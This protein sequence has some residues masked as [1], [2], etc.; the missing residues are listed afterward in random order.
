MTPA[1]PIDAELRDETSISD[2][3]ILR[4]STS[5]VQ[6]PDQSPE[7]KKPEKSLND[8][9]TKV[10]PT[11]KLP[12]PAKQQQQTRIS[13]E[14]GQTHQYEHTPEVADQKPETTN[15]NQ[16]EEEEGDTQN[17]LHKAHLIQTLQAIQYINTLRP[18]PIDYF[19]GKFID[20]PPS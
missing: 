17:E 2:L 7:S 9:I 11:F 14:Q 1:S 10:D 13:I 20:L 16:E 12:S 8:L 3:E 15:E 5:S 4:D 6:D 18:P 19:A